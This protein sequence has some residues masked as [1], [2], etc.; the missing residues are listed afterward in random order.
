MSSTNQY[1]A[2][3]EVTINGTP[4]KRFNSVRI[5]QRFDGHH[6]F[7]LSLS[8]D[9]LDGGTAAVKLKELGQKFVGELA[10]IKLKQGE[11]DKGTLKSEKQN[12]TFKGIVTGVQLS[13][14]QSATQ[15]I[16]ISGSSPTLLLNAGRTTRSFDEMTPSAIVEKIISSLGLTVSVAAT[17]NPVLPYITQY[18]ED[19]LHFVQ[20]LAEAYGQWFFYDGEKLYYGKKSA[21][22]GVTLVHGSNFFDME[23]SL[24]VAPMKMTA[25]YYDFSTDQYLSAEVT[26]NDVDGLQEFAKLVRDKSSA[27][28]KDNPVE[29]GYQNHQKDN[30]LKDV[31]KLKLSEISNKLAVLQGRTSE[32]QLKIGGTVKVKDEI[33]GVSDARQGAQLQ[34]TVDYGTFL[35]TRLSHYLDSRGIYQANFEAIPQDIDFPPVDYKISSPSASPQPAIVKRVDDDESLGRVKVQFAWQQD[36]SQTTPWVRVAQPMAYKDQGVY[37]IPEIDEVVFVDFEMGNPDLPFVR[38]SM[39]HGDKTP[40]PLFDKD[41][42]IK[43]IITRSGNHILINDESGKE[44]IKIYNKDQKNTIELLLDGGTT[45]NIK[46]EGNIN[47]EAKDTITMKAKKIDMTADQ[48]WKVKAGKSEINNDQG[49]KINANAKVEVAGQAGVKVEGATI[50]IEA[51]AKA[52]IKANAQLALESSGQASLKGTIV[53][54]N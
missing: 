26:S 44:S 25:K 7:E 24:R 18:E 54:I 32:M 23:Y 9:M 35:I 16:L 22:T 5:S 27:L 34:E 41:N 30:T 28:F 21:D 8:P 53:M 31:A 29:L 13:K 11:M 4:L 52:S 12:L 46:S 50:D 43:G 49:M 47:I 45:I 36:S 1:I 40:G 15:S 33:Y 6:D 14:G 38:G 3:A 51:Q 48:E 37:F 39:F 17:S 42:N 19:D 2:V 20:R 10:T